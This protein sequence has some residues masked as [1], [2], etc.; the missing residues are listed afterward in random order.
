MIVVLRSGA[1][2]ESVEAILG[3]FASTPEH[4]ERISRSGPSIVLRAPGVRVSS[5]PR[6][7]AL[8]GHPDV[9]TVIDEDPPFYLVSRAFQGADSR[10]V[11]GGAVFGGPALV[12]A[13]GPCSVESLDTLRRAAEAAKDAGATLLRGGAFKPRTSPYAFQGMGEPGLELLARVGAEFDLGVVTEVMSPED[14]PLVAGYASMLQI[15]SRSMQ[16]FP[17]L[18]AV[19][20]Q[21]RPVLLKRGLMATLDEFLAAAEYIVSPGNPQV[22]LCE[23]GIR[24]FETR[25]RNTLDVVAVPALR[26]LTHLPI[27]V[28]PSH[29]TGKRSLVRPAA[30]AAIAAGAD[31]LLVEVHPHPE[32]A[33][34]DGAQALLLEDLAALAR[35]LELLA[36]AVGR[37][38]P[39]RRPDRLCAPASTL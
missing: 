11:V 19:G 20:A 35:D 28:D 22:V 36:P 32:R 1:P 18:D 29:A 30:R 39:A 33:L 15:G 24:T 25:T 16:C 7:A 4:V 17:L 6:L 8:R 5:S 2:S 23:R 38:F 13:A 26:E 27:I 10:V 37:S 21:S 14:V 3:Q 34:C 12:L 9:A 31:G